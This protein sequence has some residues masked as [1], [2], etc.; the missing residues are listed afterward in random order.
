MPHSRSFLPFGDLPYAETRTQM[1]SGGRESWGK[2]SPW[3]NANIIAQQP[4]EIKHGPA[5]LPLIH[6]GVA[7]EFDK[8]P[9]AGHIRVLIATFNA[10]VSP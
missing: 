6:R 5:A 7:Q 2:T 1:R 4:S 8:K 9:F 3:R 10:N